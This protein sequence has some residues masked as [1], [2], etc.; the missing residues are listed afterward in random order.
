MPLIRLEDDVE[1]K[2]AAEGL[3]DL[4][5][6]KAEYGDNKKQTAKRV[7]LMLLVEGP[8]G[9]GILPIN[10]WISISNDDDEP[11]KKRQNLKNMKRFFA[12]FG[13]PMDNGFDPD[14]NT[15]DLVGLTGKCRVVQEED[16]S[17]EMRNRLR[18]PKV[19]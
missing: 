10:H 12:V 1:D 17:G 8:D 14:E 5:V 11:A 19:A 2:L 3:Y 6:A 15:Q 4:R 16:D 13:Y 7:A 9:D 18:L